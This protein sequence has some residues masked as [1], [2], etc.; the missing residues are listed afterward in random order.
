MPDH[1]FFGL[2]S[3]A[4]RQVVVDEGIQLLHRVVRKLITLE[5]LS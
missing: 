1:H 4:P 3:G 5:T 2:E